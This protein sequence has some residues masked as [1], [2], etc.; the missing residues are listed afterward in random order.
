MCLFEMELLKIFGLTNYKKKQKQVHSDVSP[1]IKY[2]KIK[3]NR[4]NFLKWNWL[5]NFLNLL[6]EELEH[7]KDVGNDF[8]RIEGCEMY[9]RKTNKLALNNIDVGKNI[10]V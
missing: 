2:I 5:C 10:E 4:E 1:R 8:N 9:L 6:N 3:K 7:K